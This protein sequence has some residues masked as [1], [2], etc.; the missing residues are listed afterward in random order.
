MLF[1]GITIA[2]VLGLND[3]ML[4]SLEWLLLLLAAWLFAQTGCALLEFISCKYRPLWLGFLVGMVLMHHMFFA[5]AL[6]SWLQLEIVY[7]FTII[8]CL[9]GGYRV[10]RQRPWDK[11][12]HFLDKEIHFSDSIIIFSISGITLTSFTFTPIELSHVANVL[13]LVS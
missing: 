7:S 12:Q 5:L 2:L 11:W 3:S 8:I 10:F 4:I 13:V 6:V 9:I 1:S